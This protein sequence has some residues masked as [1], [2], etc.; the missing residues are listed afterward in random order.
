MTTC[1]Y[2]GEPFIGNRDGLGL[3]ASSLWA[4]VPG[5]VISAIGVLVLIVLAVFS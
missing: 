3:H 1:R 4:A 2:C 5:L